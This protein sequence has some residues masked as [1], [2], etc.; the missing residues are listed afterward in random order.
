MC[1]GN[2]PARVLSCPGGGGNLGRTDG[3]GGGLK[4]GNKG[5]GVRPRHWQG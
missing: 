5:L 4:P 2:T 3:E 1:G